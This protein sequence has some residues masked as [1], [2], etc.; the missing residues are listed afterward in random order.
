MISLH[1]NNTETLS[2][3]EIDKKLWSVTFL[4]GVIYRVVLRLHYLTKFQFS[5]KP[6][7]MLF[8]KWDRGSLIILWKILSKAY[9]R[10]ILNTICKH[11]RKF[12][13]SAQRQRTQNECCVH[14]QKQNALPGVKQALNTLV[15][16]T[17]SR[18]NGFHYDG[19]LVLLINAWRAGAQK[20]VVFGRCLI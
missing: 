8:T 15:S 5:G 17:D 14:S 20:N 6:C 19:Y 13:P 2:T 9:F 1:T 12:E 18:L 3:R 7:P 4:D 10:G 16:A 11:G